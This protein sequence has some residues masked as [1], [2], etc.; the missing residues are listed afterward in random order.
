MMDVVKDIVTDVKKGAAAV[1][2]MTGTT[3]VVEATGMVVACLPKASWAG[4]F[5]LSNVNH[6]DRDK[7][8]ASYSS[9]DA[10]GADVL[11]IGEELATQLLLMDDSDTDDFREFK[12]RLGYS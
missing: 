4:T 12:R 10:V 8:V 11:S 1:D 9:A 3:D 6:I 2:V 7:S 5:S